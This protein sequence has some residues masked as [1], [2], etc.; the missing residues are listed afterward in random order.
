MDILARPNFI[1]L[2]IYASDLSQYNE[3]PK[4]CLQTPN[5]RAHT[6][7]NTMIVHFHSTVP[8]HVKIQTSFVSIHYKKAPIKDMA[9]AKEAYCAELRTATRQLGERC[10]YPVA[11]WYALT[12]KPCDTLG[13]RCATIRRE[14][15]IVSPTSLVG[16]QNVNL[17]C[18][19]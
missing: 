11:K 4:F 6:Y 13:P 16:S 12:S 7:L 8:H 2:E 17:L 5:S 15:R 9:S 3:Q 19:A 18:S 14:V 1:D 10:R